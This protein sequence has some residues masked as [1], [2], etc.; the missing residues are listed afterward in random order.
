MKDVENFLTPII[1]RTTGR[2]KRSL[3]D[4]NEKCPKLDKHLLQLTL[5]KTSEGMDVVSY[6]DVGA[7][8]EVKCKEGYGL[9]AE[10]YSIN[11]E[12]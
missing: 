4:G 2:R 7:T 11:N 9:L 1:G 3:G 8:I 5:I 12:C 10:R 6:N